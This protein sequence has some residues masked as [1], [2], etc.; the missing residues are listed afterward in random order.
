MDKQTVIYA[1]VDNFP[2]VRDVVISGPD[3][4]QKKSNSIKSIHPTARIFF[5]KFKYR[6]PKEDLELH[7]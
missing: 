1:L 5:G 3:D 6:I 7:R 2:I 4:F